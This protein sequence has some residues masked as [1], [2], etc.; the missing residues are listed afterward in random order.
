MP[1]LLQTIAPPRG[2]L[3]VVG[4]VHGCY[5]E[6]RELL[7]R[8]APT[9]ADV[10][11]AAGDMVRKGPNSRGCVALWRSLGYHAVRGNNEERLLRRTRHPL[12]WL[13]RPA[14]DRE[15]LVFLATWP[16]AIA[17]PELGVGVVHGG[18]LPGTRLTAEEVERQRATIP[19]LRWVRRD[20]GRWR[21]VP[22]GRKRDG[23]VLWSEVWGGAATIAYGHTPVVAPKRDPFAL[24]LDTGCVYGGALTAAIHRDGEWTF[25]RV[26][27]RQAY[28]RE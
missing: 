27:A 3:I 28:V 14:D 16:I 9:A 6:L 2:R 20:G 17:I 19:R 23:D 13:T 21:Y 18:L 25:E 8:V 15:M 11:I 1:P 22:K 5:D 7:S 4:D 10:V 26:R 24:G 12:A